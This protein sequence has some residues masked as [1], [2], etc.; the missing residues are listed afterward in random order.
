[1]KQLRRR[2]RNTMPYYVVRLGTREDA[3]R[4]ELYEALVDAESG[5]KDRVK[6]VVVACLGIIEKHIAPNNPDCTYGQS[7]RAIRDEIRGVWGDT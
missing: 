1:M 4:R 3:L 5:G 7:A 6:R 2:R